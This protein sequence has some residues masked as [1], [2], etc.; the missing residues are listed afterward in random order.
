MPVVFA[1]LWFVGYDRACQLQPYLQKQ[2]AAGSA[3]AKLLVENVEFLVDKFHCEKHTKATCLP[4]D[5]PLCKYH[6]QLPKFKEI[7]GTNTPVNKDSST[8]MHT[9]VQHER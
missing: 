5:N 8:S 7:H 2:A 3:G 1:R 6:P 4:V 9:S